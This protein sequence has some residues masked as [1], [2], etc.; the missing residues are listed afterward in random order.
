MS[1]PWIRPHTS[2]RILPRVT[3][4][5]LNKTLST[6]SAGRLF[7]RTGEEIWAFY[8]E[9]DEESRSWTEQWEDKPEASSKALAPEM[10]HVSTND[11]WEQRFY[12]LQKQL[13]DLTKEDEAC[14]ISELS[15]TEEHMCIFYGSKEHYIEECEQ[16]LEYRE[17]MY[18]QWWKQQPSQ[19]F[20]QPP[21]N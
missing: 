19:N 16:I 8:E 11:F 4:K 17:V 2:S 5:E 14:I 10:Y 9:A 12:A 21:W 7:Q 20:T 13:A 3:N 18:T 15:V 1:T 6:M